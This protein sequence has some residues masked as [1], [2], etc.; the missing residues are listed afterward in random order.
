MEKGM[1]IMEKV[2]DGNAYLL[3]DLSMNMKEAAEFIKKIA[4]VTWKKYMDDRS[5]ILL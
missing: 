4:R 2:Q 5:R 1:L 3:S